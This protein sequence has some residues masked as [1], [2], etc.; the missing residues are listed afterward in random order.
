MS[1]L[2]YSLQMWKRAEE[3]PMTGLVSSRPGG[4]GPGSQVTYLKNF[5]NFDYHKQ[6]K[7]VIKMCRQHLSARL[8]A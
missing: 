5:N 3:A 8:K 4:A 1:N 6:M 2:C 7:S